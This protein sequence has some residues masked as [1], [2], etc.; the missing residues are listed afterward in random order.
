MRWRE[1]G[2]RLTRELSPGDV[3]LGLAWTDEFHLRPFFGEGKVTRTLADYCRR[4]E[5]APD[6]VRIHLVSST[7]PL[8]TE[9]RHFHAGAIQAITYPRALPDSTLARIRRDLKRTAGNEVD[10][11]VTWCCKAIYDI[12][13]RLGLEEE[14]LASHS[15]WQKCRSLLDSEEDVPPSLMKARF[16]D[17]EL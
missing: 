17:P 1:A 3:V 15:R 9:G 11:R 7:I 8:D 14:V 16:R 2:A 12:E 5:P 10:S 13:R 6:S 4:Q